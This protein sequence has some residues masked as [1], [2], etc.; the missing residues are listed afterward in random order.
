MLSNTSLSES[1]ATL[2]CYSYCL[3]FQIHHCQRGVLLCIVRQAVFWGFH[4]YAFKYIAVREMCWF[5]LL[6]RL[7]SGG[8]IAMLSSTS[9]SGVL[10][11][12]VSQAVSWVFH[13]YAMLT[14]NGNNIVQWML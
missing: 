14:L 4:C 13:C 5:A 6:V 12:I 11:Y 3:C 8:F 7:F 10:L 1:C 2:H 9:L